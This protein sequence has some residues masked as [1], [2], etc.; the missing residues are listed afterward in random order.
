[1]SDNKETTIQI[2]FAN[3]KAAHHFALWFCN[4]GEQNYWESME[5]AELDEDGDIT[6]NS[7]HCHGEED[8]SKATTDPT[9]Y[10]DFMCDNIIRTT[11]GRLDAD[12]I[13]YQD[14]SLE[15]EDE[16]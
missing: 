7:F 15:D 6:A 5:T 3:P 2:R 9:R 8:E 1:M 12:E 10:G 14:V 11:V 13:V 16:L 4:I